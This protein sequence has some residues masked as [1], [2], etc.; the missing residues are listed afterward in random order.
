MALELLFHRVPPF[1]GGMLQEAY[2]VNLG[3]RR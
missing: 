2:D 3:I 1:W